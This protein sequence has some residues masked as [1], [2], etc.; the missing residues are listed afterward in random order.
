MWKI[1]IISFILADERAEAEV[2]DLPPDILIANKK[3][4]EF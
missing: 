4:K 3:K 1:V 2:S